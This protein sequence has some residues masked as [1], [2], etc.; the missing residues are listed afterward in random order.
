M[1]LSTRLHQHLYLKNLAITGIILATL[2][3]LAFLSYR[4][5]QEIDLTANGSNTLSAGTQKVLASLPDELQITVYIKAMHPLKRQIKPLLERYQHHKA[6]LKIR[7]V[8]PEINLEKARELNVGSQG[9]IVVEYKGRSEKINFLDESTLTNALLQLATNKERWVSF[10]A[11]HGE[12]S[13]TGV[14]NFDL[15][16]FG[17]ELA[18]R[19][20]KAQA[21]NLA[22]VGGIPDN[23]ALLVLAAPA[24]PLLA[25]ELALVQEYIKQGGNLLL[26]TDP[27]DKHFAVIEKQL[28]VH[29]LPGTVVDTSSKLYKIEDP[30]FVLVSQYPR[31]PITQGMENIT[32]YPVASALTADKNS[33]F[34][35][36][37]FLNSIAKSWT[38]TSEIKGEIRFDPNTQEQ[39]GPL[40]I[41]YALTREIKGNNPHQQR[42]VV[43]GDGDFLANTFLGNVGNMDMGMR[44]F[45]WLTHDDQFID[46]PLKQAKGKSLQLSPVAIGVIGFGFLFVVPLGLMG[47]GFW[48]WRSRKRR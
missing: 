20:I 13:P 43:I 15:G 30:S 40:S 32:V 6:N 28:G 17:K 9:L 48:I 2:S 26:L 14:A 22:E 21:L 45:N 25:G 47:A 42:I 23:S 44:I 37:A 35:A 24:V 12:R 27:D 31:H 16:S 33:D 11:G 41:G 4:Y 18:Q 39:Q 1:K 34:K 19:N 5:H 3:G 7:F 46:I 38:E 8:D 10:L 29:K 36:T